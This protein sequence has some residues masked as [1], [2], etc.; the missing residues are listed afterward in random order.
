MRRGTEV[1]HAHFIANTFAS[2]PTEP[3]W[4]FVAGWLA[5]WTVDPVAKG[6]SL[7]HGWMRDCF[8]NSSESTLDGLVSACFALYAEHAL[9]SLCALKI[10]CSSSRG[11]DVGQLVEHWTIGRF[12]SP[13]RLGIFLP[14]STFTADCL[15]VH[16]P[17]AIAC[18]YICVHVEVSVIRVR[19][20]WIME[21][22]KHPA[23]ALG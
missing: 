19:V 13:V 4:E 3:A 7:G 11:G 8:C 14:E 18:V 16:P 6:P 15:S 2:V 5:C 9:R 12:D 23:C 22:L 10:T 21:T 17:C 20:W 1:I